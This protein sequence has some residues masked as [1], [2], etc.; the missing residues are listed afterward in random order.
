MNSNIVLQA[1]TMRVM[2]R[3]NPEMSHYHSETE[4]VE[5]VIEA[6]ATKILQL[7]SKITSLEKN[8]NN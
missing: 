7:E 6:L 3:A 1:N 4:S 5:I 2:R 8:E